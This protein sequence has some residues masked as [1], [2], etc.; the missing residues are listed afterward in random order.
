MPATVGL[1]TGNGDTEEGQEKKSRAVSARLNPDCGS[2]L[3]HIPPA[4][5]FH[6]RLRAPAGRLRG[7]EAR[8]AAKPIAER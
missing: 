6:G 8:S 2:L 3:A 5:A 7:L 4:D 1:T